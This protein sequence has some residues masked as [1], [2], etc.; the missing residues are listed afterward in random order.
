[1]IGLNLAPDKMLP[2]GVGRKRRPRKQVYFTLLEQL[3]DDKNVSY[4]SAFSAFSA[5]LVYYNEPINVSPSTK[6]LPFIGE[7]RLS[8]GSLPMGPRHYRQAPIC[9]RISTGDRKQKSQPYKAKAP[10]RRFQSIKLLENTWFLLC[11][12]S[13]AN[14]MKTDFG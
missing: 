12:F 3:L 4:H 10:G 5:A 8:R 11:G 1:M 7:N 14:S 9:G 13:N 2:E 6:L